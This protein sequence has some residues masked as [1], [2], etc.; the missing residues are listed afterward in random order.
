MAQGAAGVST[1]PP[2]PVA[3]SAA[4]DAPPAATVIPAAAAAPSSGDAPPSPPVFG[5]ALRPKGADQD[6]TSQ[7]ETDSVEWAIPRSRSASDSGE[8]RVLESGEEDDRFVD[9]NFSGL[10]TLE[11][12]G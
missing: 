11:D 3:A 1:A 7:E 2:S 12:F 4:A 10:Q 8:S 6:A 9:R 5:A